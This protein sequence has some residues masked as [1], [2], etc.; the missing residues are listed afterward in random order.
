MIKRLTPTASRALLSI[1]TFVL[2]AGGICLTT[3]AFGQKH[4]NKGGTKDL[5]T[6][7]RQMPVVIRDSLP[8]GLHILF[9][10]INEIPLAEISVVV[11]AGIALETNDNHGAAYG[12]N[13]LLLAGSSNRAGD[14]VANY[15]SELGSVVYPYLH[16][17]YA[18]LYAKTLTRSF[19]GTLAVMADAVSAPSL[20]EQALLRLKRDASLRLSRKSS[21][22]ERATIMAVQRLCGDGHVMSRLLQPTA[23]EVEA[24]TIEK[25]RAYHATWYQPRRTTVII[26]GNLEYAFVRTA[27]L[28]AFGRWENR[29]NVKNI[30]VSTGALDQSVVVVPDSTTLNGR[31]YFRIGGRALLRNDD[32]FLAQMLLNNILSDGPQSRLHQTLWSKHLVSPNFSTAVAFSRDCSYFMIS[33]S[34]SPMLTDS[35]LLFV[36]EAIV[37]IA[38]EGVTEKELSA[39]KNSLLTDDALS[40]GLN[41]NLQSLLKEMTV[42]GL[43]LEQLFAFSA[44]IRAV[45]SK[46]IQ[47]V[48]QTVLDPSRLQTVVLGSEEKIVRFIRSM[49]K[50]VRIVE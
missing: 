22:G 25:L 17:D 43:S 13:Q 8:N 3:P 48:A 39:A 46:D 47:R 26:T 20:P 7:G 14:M 24:L 6:Q 9:T 5:G 35:V 33:G 18:Q 2:I 1:F 50:K 31:A 19:S 40:Y 16:Y 15:L 11:D 44:N 27:L 38:R 42:Y 32:D 28:E 30:S 49:G 36:Q 37:D 29:E 4:K 12:V 21:S 23:E 45:S 34:A 41:R 10:R